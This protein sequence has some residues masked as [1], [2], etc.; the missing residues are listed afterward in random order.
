MLQSFARHE[1][2]CPGLEQHFALCFEGRLA[3]ELRTLNA[4]VSMLGNTRLKRPLSI[5]RARRA[6][7]SLIERSGCDIVIC[8]G[9]RSMMFFAATVRNS[10]VVL[11]MWVHGIRAHWR[12]LNR[13]AGRV[14]PDLQ[15]CNSQYTMTEVADVLPVV[16][17]AMGAATEI[18]DRN[19]GIL[20]TA[21]NSSALAGAL[22]NL[23]TD[24]GLRQRLGS[25]GP[26][27]ARC[28]CDPAARLNELQAT[29]ASLH[30]PSKE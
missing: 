27:R 14:R 6:L 28:L 1:A 9:P 10:G 18:V 23:L 12:W 25:A 2:L 19:T 21:D 26:A 13:L 8:H 11:V 7:R 4:P 29:L 17:S 16:T 15:I 20:V 5:R 3:D 22:R 30:S 24:P